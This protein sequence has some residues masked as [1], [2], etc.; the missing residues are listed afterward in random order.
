MCFVI[1]SVFLVGWT[2]IG[3]T[4]ADAV[5]TDEFRDVMLKMSRG[6]AIIM[7]CVYVASRVYQVNPPGEDSIDV[8]AE[9]GGHEAFRHEE[10][11]LKTEPP[12]LSP[13]FCFALLVVLVGLIGVTAEWL[14][15]SIETV[16]QGANIEEEYVCAIISFF[17]S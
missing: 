12:K 3:S 13:W 1:P 7:L 4:T 16:R 15:A 10:E 9:A 11:A 5:I 14:V 8:Y 17:L 6:M 2:R